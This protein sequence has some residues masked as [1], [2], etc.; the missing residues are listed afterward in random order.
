MSER[1]WLRSYELTVGKGGGHGIKTSSLRV[2]FE[3]RKG[4]SESPNEAVIKVWNLS[5]ETLQKSRKEFDRVILQAGYA[6][7]YGLIYSGNIIGQRVIRENGTDAVLELTCG[8]GDEAYTSAVMN[9]T[10][11]AGASQKEI[12]GAVRGSFGEY[13]VSP[14]E[15]PELG[16]QRL[17][18]GKVMFGM[19]RKFARE[20][21]Y[22]NGSSWSVQDGKMVMVKN[23]GYLPGEAVVLTSKTGLVGAPEQTNDGVKVKCLL[24]P[25]IR[26]NGRVKIDNS[27]VT[28]A[29]K[30]TGKD[31]KEPAALS[32]DGFYR[33]LKIVYIGD[34]H[35]QDWYCDMV[36][37]SIDATVGKTTDTRGVNR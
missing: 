33:V 25:K 2:A 19:T 11:A 27:S 4:D 18:R 30:E 7:N 36:C 32:S 9:K 20:S 14:G 34:T 37:V 3:I 10:L 8:D 1:Q 5:D 15:T 12:V 28:E 29:K 17:P 23:D 26:V 22:T 21:A 16:S 24:N 31:A 6:E 35:G 13:G